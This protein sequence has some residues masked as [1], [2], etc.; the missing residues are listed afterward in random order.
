M[1][2]VTALVCT[3]NRPKQIANTV[4][5]LLDGATDIELI[6]VD[7][8]PDT[9]TAEALSL[10]RDDARF[11]YHRSST[12]GKGAGLN[13]GLGIAR[14]SIVVLTDDDC[15]AP[16]G[17]VRAMAQM[18]A[19]RPK[20]AVLFCNVAPVQHDKNAGYVPSYERKDSRLLTSVSGLRDG[21]G[22]G[23]GMALRKDTALA[24]GGFDESF[25]PGS[26]F[27]SADEWDLC[28]RALISGWQVYE[29]PEL[30]ILHDGFRSFE[31]GRAHAS[32]DWVALGAVCTKPLRAGH[33]RAVVVP[34]YFLPSKTL[35]PALSDLLHL[36][37]PRGL[38][39]VVAFVSGFKDGMRTPLDKRTLRFVGPSP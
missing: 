30:S 4:R 24:L 25:G 36:R 12:I 14:G 21:L 6:V 5:S 17:W 38:G 26:R 37:R 19:A 20:V 28:I 7:Q 27:P 29:T 32:R 10:W 15:E 9:A 1:V 22:L 13:Q 18:L 16:P 34:L 23:A 2:D 11:S 39:R 8:S 3:R 31:E 33:L 35:L